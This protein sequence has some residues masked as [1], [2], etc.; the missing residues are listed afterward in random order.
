MANIM[1]VDPG[2][3]K[4]GWAVLTEEGQV[5]SHAVE[6]RKKLVQLFQKKQQVF[7]IKV[8]VLGNGTGSAALKQELESALPELAIELIDEYK[9]TEQARSRYWQENPPKGWRRL[10]PLGLQVPP[11]PVDDYVA[12][13]LAEK[14]IK[15]SKNI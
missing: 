6:A 15:K 10:I 4:C 8:L 14:Y 7:D 13:L 12:I 11:E 1:A 2:R 9:T 3:E 5:L